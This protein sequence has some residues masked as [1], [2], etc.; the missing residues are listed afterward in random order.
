M[1]TYKVIQDIEAEDHILGPLTLRQFIYGLICA[2]CLYL[3]FIGFSKRVYPLL[4]IFFPPA[5]LTGFFAFPFRQDQPTEIW[6]LAKVRFMFKPRRRVWS[7][8]GIKELVT[9]TV[10]KK[11][12]PQL[13]KNMDQEQVQSRLK[14]LASTIDSRGWAIKNVDSNMYSQP[15][16]RLVT[17]DTIHREVPELDIRASDDIFDSQSSPLSAHFEQ[18]IGA[19]TENRR[20]QLTATLTGQPAPSN[21]PA[22]SMDKDRSWFM[23]PVAPSVAPA[24]TANSHMRTLQPLSDGQQTALPATTIPQPPSS[25]SVA[26]PATPDPAILNLAGNNDLN[27]AT[28]AREAQKA[29]QGDGADGEVV[30]SLH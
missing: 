28:L 3:C 25:A 22:P 4:I 5:L 11:F 18:M 16:D 6:A 17:P 21:L 13:T 15:S 27:V 29:K 23:N 12:E 30:I 7:Q 26:S 10:P 19:T 2:F 1:A 8:S 14:A 20:Q 9:I 24:P